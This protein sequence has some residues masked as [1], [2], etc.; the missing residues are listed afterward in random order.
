[1]QLFSLKPVLLG[2]KKENARTAL[3][4]A[5]SRSVF[6]VRVAAAGAEAGGGTV[7]LPAE[8]EPVGLRERGSLPRGVGPRLFC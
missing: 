1:M 2:G 6:A 8:S 5:A 3:G 4:R 7:F